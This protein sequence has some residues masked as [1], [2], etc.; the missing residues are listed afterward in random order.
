MAIG[1]PNN[2][3]QR[4]I[5]TLC[6][7]QSFACAAWSVFRP[8]EA[9]YSFECR[10]RSRPNGATQTF[11]RTSQTLN[12]S[13][14]LYVPPHLNTGASSS[15]RNSASV[16]TRYSKEQLLEIYRAQS[17]TGAFDD[18]L[19]SLLT[20]GWAPGAH[21]SSVNGWGRKEEVREGHAGADVCWQHDGM[22]QPLGL[23]PLD[24]D[25]KEVRVISIAG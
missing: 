11:R 23:L 3:A 9:D 1:T 13:S 19:P 20:E 5:A 24:E 2:Q 18:Q 8:I 10:S 4:Y 21:G 16:N 12:Q 22:V 7:P 25:E 17:E 15:P 6:R 14:G